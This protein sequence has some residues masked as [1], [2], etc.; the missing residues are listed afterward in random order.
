MRIVNKTNN[1]PFG[2]LV[3]EPFKLH[4]VS[5]LENFQLKSCPL[6]FES[7]RVCPYCHVYLSRI[8]EI[9]NIP[10][11]LTIDLQTILGEKIIVSVISSQLNSHSG[12]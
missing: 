9:A 4:D 10:F 7:Q 12:L 11:Q 6:V 1:T 8:G 3:I 2:S 5:V